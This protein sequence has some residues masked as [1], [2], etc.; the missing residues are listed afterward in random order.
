[1]KIEVYSNRPSDIE[2]T[3]IFTIFNYRILF[4]GFGLRVRDVFN[5]F[6]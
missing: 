2:S 6:M 1:M 5:D 4:A 3:P